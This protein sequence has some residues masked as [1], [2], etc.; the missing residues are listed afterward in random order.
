[1]SIV[2][3]TPLRVPTGT[4]REQWSKSPRGCQPSQAEHGARARRLVRRL[5]AELDQPLR[6]DRILLNKV[7]G[8]RELERCPGFPLPLVGPVG[9]SWELVDRDDHNSVLATNGAGGRA[10]TLREIMKRS[11]ERL[12]GKAPADAHGR[13]PLLVKHLD[14]RQPLSV[15]VH[16]DEAGA[17][18]VGG[19]SESKCEAAIVLAADPGA[20]IYAGLKPEVT[21][22]QLRA[23]LGGPDLLGLLNAY[24]ARPGQCYLI[25]GGTVHAHGAGLVLFEVQQNSDTTYRLWDFGRVGDDGKP[26]A[27]HVEQALAVAQFGAP[28]RAPLEPRYDDT[29]RGHGRA[30]L[31]RTQSFA[32]NALAIHATTRLSTNGQFQIYSALRGSGRLTVRGSSAACALRPGDVWLVPAALDYHYVEPDTGGLELIQVLYRA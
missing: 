21:P 2:P 17:R 20:L 27:V 10:P 5:S 32:L 7:W 14:A 1:M 6:F 18:R 11:G 24:E 3:A 19:D 26:R 29:G 9:E 15:Q 4:T 13:F 16:P 28:E 12:L 31:A 30:P 8:G 25:P 22:A 23:A